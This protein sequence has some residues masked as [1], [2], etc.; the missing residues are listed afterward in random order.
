MTGKPGQAALTA[1]EQ[2][3]FGQALIKQKVT[4]GFIGDNFRFAARQ[5]SVI[6][7][8][9]ALRHFRQPD[10]GTWRAWNTR[11]FK[12]LDGEPIWPSERKLCRRPVSLDTPA[13][14]QTTDRVKLMVKTNQRREETSAFRVFFHEQWQQIQTLSRVWRKTA[15]ARV[16]LDQAVEDVVERTN[17]RLRIVTGYRNRLR[18][19]VREILD[20]VAEEVKQ[21]PSA[22]HIA[23]ERYAASEQL[24]TYF[25]NIDTIKTICG[26]NEDIRGFFRSPEG[27]LCENAYFSLLMTRREKSVFGMA[28]ID[29]QVV[30]EVPQKLLYFDDHAVHGPSDSEDSARLKLEKVLFD[31]I[32]DYLRHQ[33][34]L[35]SAEHGCGIGRAKVASRM[36]PDA[37][38]DNLTRVLAEPRDLLRVE[39]GFLRVSKLGV[40]L[41]V[42]EK[43]P[44]NGIHCNEIA[45]GDISRQAIILASYA[46]KDVTLN[47]EDRLAAARK[48]LGLDDAA[49]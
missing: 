38:F 43:E 49:D 31:R 47:P 24:N 21:L 20:H 30:K 25:Q 48:A 46:Q 12:F 23:P 33:M 10:T 8:V 9:R 42:G 15:R 39:S 11:L 28:L 6:D 35:K 22:V 19:A 17:A 32:V 27:A 41:T 44:S 45:V 18:G 13:P 16:A 37:Y 4:H 36:S 34:L 7:G 2:P 3:V 40:K 29:D 1:V 14:I 26:Q 5:R